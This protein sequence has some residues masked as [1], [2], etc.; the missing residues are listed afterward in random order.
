MPAN[1]ISGQTV[2]YSIIN[3]AGGLFDIDATTGVVQV[4]GILDFETAENY[5]IELMATS[6]DGSFT[7]A[8]FSIALL[9]LP[10]IAST[11]IGTGIQRSAI[12]K[13]EV[14][15]DGEVNLGA[16]AFSLIQRSDF[17]GLTGT[18]IA[19]SFTTSLNADGNTV[20]TIQFL[21]GTRSSG[22]LNDGNYQLTIDHTQV[23]LVS[24]GMIMESDFVF[25][26]EEADDFFAMY[27]D[28]NGDR[29]V[30]VLDLL[31]FRRAYRTQQGD[32][33]YDATLDYNG[34]GQ[35]NALDLLRFRQ[36]YRKTL[37]YL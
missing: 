15:F 14:T 31:M 37:Q 32:D 8:E 6:S 5:T 7:T 12:D 18:S 1:R 27:G 19:T 16:N 17:N 2:T 36:K 4:A 24:T 26:D 30:S 20:A 29:T 25:G 9:D 11:T 10:E 23:M 28:V 21:S 22:A 3:D 13:L 34:D 35:I 33:D